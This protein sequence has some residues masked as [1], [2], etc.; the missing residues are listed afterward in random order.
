[1]YPKH[2]VVLPFLH[3]LSYCSL[4]LHLLIPSR[5]MA[6][7]REIIRGWNVEWHQGIISALVTHNHYFQKQD[8]AGVEDRRWVIQCLTTGASASRVLFLWLR[9]WPIQYSHFLGSYYVYCQRSQKHLPWRQSWFVIRW[10]LQYFHKTLYFYL[11][12][13]RF[14]SLASVTTIFSVNSAWWMTTR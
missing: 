1:M 2:Q 3:L 13:I 4:P 12:M 9:D 11:V 7:T 8:W 10:I 6:E 14:M 5:A